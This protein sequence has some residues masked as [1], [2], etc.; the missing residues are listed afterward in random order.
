MINVGLLATGGIGVPLHAMSS[1][2]LIAILPTAAE[3]EVRSGAT[4]E[5]KCIAVNIAGGEPW[6]VE[7]SHN[8]ISG[9]AG[10]WNA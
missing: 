4:Q 6:F 1:L 8:A 2:P 7:C 10:I 5:L 3:T 9:E